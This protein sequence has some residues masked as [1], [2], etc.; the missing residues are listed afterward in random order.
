MLASFLALVSPV[1]AAPNRG[2]QVTVGSVGNVLT[3][4][5]ALA[6]SALERGIA[7]CLFSALYRTDPADGFVPDLLTAMPVRKG[8][9]YHY[10]LRRGVL[11]SDGHELTAEDV[12]FTWETMANP[13]VPVAD[14]AGWD[15]IASCEIP[16]VAYEDEDGRIRRRPD[17]YRFRITLKEP[18]ARYEMLWAGTAILPK[19]VVEKEMR[20]NAARKARELLDWTGPFSRR[21]VGSGPFVLKEWRPDQYLVLARNPRYFR[22]GLPYLDRVVIKLFTDERALLTQLADGAIDLCRLPPDQYAEAAR[23]PGMTVQSSPG[24]DYDCILMNLNDPRDPG[25][26][27][28]ILGDRRVRQALEYAFPRESIVETVLGGAGFPA[29]TYL[30]PFSWAHH[31]ELDAPRHSP[32]KAARLLDE[33]G[34]MAGEDGLRRRDGMPLRVTMHANAGLKTRERIAQAC[35]ESWREIG[36]DLEVRL[37]DAATLYADLMINRRFEM[38]MTGWTT[39]GDPDCSALFGAGPGGGSFTGYRNGELEELLREG[40]TTPD[41]LA[42]R[43]IYRRVQE[44]LAEDVPC[45]FID[46]HAVLAAASGRV[47]NFRV[48]PTGGT[49]FWNVHEWY[50]ADPA[51]P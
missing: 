46:F 4:N 21:P 5:P 31:G 7:Q 49:D 27:H 39:D 1:A 41:R 40:L 2:G 8:L 30:P 22:P 28:P 38:L 43:R 13:K 35:R 37:V 50:V 34:W 44:I 48:N 45:I 26:P 51:V 12:K 17:K 3:L 33:A 9:T 11:F 32:E 20:E 29:Y 23:I 16:S 19:H 15:T 6:E 42:R 14:R 47:A 36:V 24:N 18:S 25:K 10:E